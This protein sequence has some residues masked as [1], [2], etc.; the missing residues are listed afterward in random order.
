M[1]VCTYIL[2]INLLYRSPELTYHSQNS[3][4]YFSASI[5]SLVGFSSPTL[6]SLSIAITN[7][8]FTVVS[9]FLI[10]S[11]GRRRM[12]L[13]SIPIMIIG[14]LLSV[15]S[16][17]FLAI[18]FPNDLDPTAYNH[19]TTTKIKTMSTAPSS[20]WPLL[21]L[22]SLTLYVCGY[23]LGIGCV[24]W[25]QSELFPL[26]V[27]SLGSSLSTATN[28]TANFLVGL[29]F[30][31]MMQFLTP[32]V[33]FGTYAVV[34]SVGWVVVRRIYPETTGLGLEDV[35]A[36]LKDGWGVERVSHPRSR[37]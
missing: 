16:F 21:T 1:W 26:S 3:L 32:S 7:F 19:E 9:L 18:P 27:R 11:V 22:L 37:R 5:F 4:M 23:A 10:D 24:P 25:Q 30:L 6:A 20:V 12:L 36:L 28:W 2:A 35:G 31:P 8:I 29:T 13:W 17:A 15:L 14:L 34:C 33:T